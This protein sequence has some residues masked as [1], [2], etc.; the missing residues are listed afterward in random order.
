VN[1]KYILTN[2]HTT[3]LGLAPFFGGVLSM[4]AGAAAL[5]HIPIPGV[6]ITGDPW[7]MLGNGLMAASAGMAA[8][9]AKDANVTGGVKPNAQ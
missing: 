7:N 5:A 6:T 3:V 2:W 8:F 9:A 1:L 4:A